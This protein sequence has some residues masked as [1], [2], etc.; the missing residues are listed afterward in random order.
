VPNDDFDAGILDE[1]QEQ[2][3]GLLIR[4]T[5]RPEH[6]FQAALRLRLIENGRLS[7]AVGYHQS[8]TMVCRSVADGI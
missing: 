1:F 2:F 4:V 8:E 5:E 7:I 6:V 3:V